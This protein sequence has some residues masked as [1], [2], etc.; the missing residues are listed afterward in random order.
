MWTRR[1]RNLIHL[2][3]PEVSLHLMRFSLRGAPYVGEHDFRSISNL[4]RCPQDA[5]DQ[6]V[7]ELATAFAKRR[8]EKMAGHNPGMER[9]HSVDR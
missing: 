1:N 7:F 9:T 2:G 8:I 6:V 3:G 5:D 4:V